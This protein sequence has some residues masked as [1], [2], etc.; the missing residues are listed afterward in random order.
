MTDRYARLYH[1]YDGKESCGALLSKPQ[2]CLDGS[3][4]SQNAVAYQQLVFNVFCFFTSSFVGS[5]SDEYGRKGV[6]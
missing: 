2:S 3:A 5:L 4:D 1:G 6:V